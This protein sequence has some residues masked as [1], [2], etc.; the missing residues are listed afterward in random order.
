MRT[1]ESTRGPALVF[2]QKLGRVIR[3][4]DLTTLGVST[5]TLAEEAMRDGRL[6]DAIALTAYFRQEM[7][8]LHDIMTTWITDIFRQLLVKE[9]A[10]NQALPSGIMRPFRTFELGAGRQRKVEDALRE[11]DTARA[12]AEID[13]MRLEYKNLHDVLIAWVHDLFTY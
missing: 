9:G 2:S 11:G 6:E 5:Q 4:D 12:E 10:T 3:Q 1:T 8:I 13:Y 7:Q